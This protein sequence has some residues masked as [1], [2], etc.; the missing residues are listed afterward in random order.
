MIEITLKF[1]TIA[2]AAAAMN[3]FNGTQLGAT[4]IVVKPDAK[5]A[6]VAE[7]PKAEKTAAAQATQAAAP[8]Q[9][10]AVTPPSA[11]TVQ[12]AAQAVDYPTLQKA[13][14][15]LSG[16]VKGAELDATEHILGIAKS[17]GAENF[18]TLAPAQW[19][20]ALAKVNAKIA[21]LEA[22]LQAA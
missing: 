21:A 7:K 2:E 5:P 1:S 17:M 13:V 22:D 15:K 18:K 20:E 6:A 10:A 3:Q 16:I 11:A 9:E 14:F 4:T 8:D 12:T 19:T